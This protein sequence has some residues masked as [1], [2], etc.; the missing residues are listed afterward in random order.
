MYCGQCGKKVMDN[1]LFCPFCGS[2]IVIPEQDE[3]EAAVPATETAPAAEES[4]QISLFEK[5]EL[6]E[7]AEEETESDE[8][9]FEPL[10]FSFDDPDS[11][12]DDDDEAVSDEDFAA[13]FGDDSEDDED[14]DEDFIPDILLLEEESIDS[15][16]EEEAEPEAEPAKE[17]PAPKPVRPERRKAPEMNRRRENKTYIPVKEV[18]VDNLFMDE[19]DLE[20]DADEYDL[21]DDFD[22]GFEDEF[23]FEE[24]EEGS[25]VQRHIR[26]IVGLILMLV[27]ALIILI[28]AMSGKGQ[29]TLAKLNLAWDPEV[30]ADLGFEAYHQD[31][32]LLAARYY[33]KALARDPE[34]YD[35]AHSA[36]VAYYEADR[37]ESAASMLKKCVEMRPD[38]AEPY[39]EM[40][41]LYPDPA[42]RPWEIKEL[43]RMGYQRTGDASLNIQ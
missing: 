13:A 2:P 21:P 8:E 11:G 9:E 31:S 25:F 42:N 19:E 16:E 37:I 17:E 38:S 5:K 27:L 23:E 41:I 1:M 29:V 39:Q 12:F 3:P 20:E 26:G 43:I 32:D 14:D 15:L 4:R 6:P 18:D 40:L 24:P 10:S 28:W 22:A 34:N 36:M 7:D 33:E 30:Y 35:Y